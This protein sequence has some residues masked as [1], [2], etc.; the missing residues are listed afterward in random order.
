MKNKFRVKKTFAFGK[1]SC[2]LGKGISDQKQ[3][4]QTE[5]HEI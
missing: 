3:S 5:R 4:S 2:L 1:F